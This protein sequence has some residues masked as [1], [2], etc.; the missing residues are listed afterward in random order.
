MLPQRAIMEH[1]PMPVFLERRK[2]G[3]P[4][5]ENLWTCFLFCT[6]CFPRFFCVD[7][8]VFLVLRHPCVLQVLTPEDMPKKTTVHCTC[9]LKLPYFNLTPWQTIIFRNIGDYFVFFARLLKNIWRW[10]FV[11]FRPLLFVKDIL[12]F[13]LP[14]YSRKTLSSN[15]SLLSM[16]GILLGY[17]YLS[18]LFLAQPTFLAFSAPYPP[19]GSLFTGSSDTA[20]CCIYILDGDFPSWEQQG[21]FKIL[22][23]VVGSITSRWSGNEPAILPR[24]R[25]WRKSSL[26]V[27]SLRTQCS[28]V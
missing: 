22:Y 16:R 25:K 20:I 19:L 15:R 6:F 14:V 3:L 18:S 24:T 21:V 10:T 23:S 7:F 11:R 2:E 13:T 27:L 26:R 9:C 1:T 5:C 12:L 17:T 28:L 4:R 8:V